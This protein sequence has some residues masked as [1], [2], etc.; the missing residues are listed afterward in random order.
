MIKINDFFMTQISPVLTKTTQILILMS[1]Q[2]YLCNLYI[3]VSIAFYK[4]H[5]TYSIGN[6]SD[7]G[8]IS[9]PKNKQ[10]RKK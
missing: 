2:K 6:F 3:E 7:S 1:L 5:V 10:K 4:V 8:E 9:S